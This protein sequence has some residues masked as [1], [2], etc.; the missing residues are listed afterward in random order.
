MGLSSNSIIHFTKTSESLKGI[1]QENFKVK[2]CLEMINL[3]TELNYAAP[4]VSFCDIPL[5]QVKEHIGKYGA[6]GIGLTKEWAQKNKLNPVLYIQEKS[7][8]AESIQSTYKAIPSKKVEWDKLSLVDQNFM[9]ILRH[10][11]N[12]EADL[13]RGGKVIKNYRFSDE[14]EWR[15]T[16]NY[17]SCNKMA[18]HP[19]GYKTEEQKKKINKELKDVYLEFEPNDIKYIIIERESEI[20]EFLEILKKSKG[21]I[22]SYNDVERLMTRIITSEQIKSDL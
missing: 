11:K 3:E 21:N 18:I 8:L 14:R 20:S 9:N 10:I 17:E 5:S 4:M 15:F 7:F 1:L 19:N 22:Y 6:Y 12:Y 16:P 13:S 2:F